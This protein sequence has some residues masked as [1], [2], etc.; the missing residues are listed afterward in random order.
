MLSSDNAPWPVPF[1]PL[2][3][4]VFLSAVTIIT[5]NA[6]GIALPPTPVILPLGVYPTGEGSP[7]QAVAGQQFNGE[8]G[9]FSYE[10]SANPTT[11]QLTIDWGDGTTSGGTL[12]TITLPNGQ[13]A[14][15]VFGSHVYSQPGL[16]KVVAHANED[17]GLGYD[18]TFGTTEA[19]ADITGNPAETGSVIA[20]TNGQQY[21][22][23][24]GQFSAPNG[25]PADAQVSINW[26]DGSTSPGQ[27]VLETDGAYEIVGSHTFE[28]SNNGAYVDHLFAITTTV[29]TAQSQMIATVQSVAVVS[30]SQITGSVIDATS[31]D[32]FSGAL[33][34]FDASLWTD[35]PLYAPNDFL[36][37]TID[38]GDGDQ[39]SGQ[40]NQLSTGAYQI[41]G[42]H[43]YSQNGYYV[44]QAAVWELEPVAG[45]STPAYV[46]VPAIIFSAFNVQSPPAVSVTV[47][48]NNLDHPLFTPNFSTVQI[49][50]DNWLGDDTNLLGLLDN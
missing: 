38:W 9:F 20:A 15:G 39:T 7:I 22:G 47:P 37:A 8:V 21:T 28:L 10:V 29:S 49:T 48:V 43:A 3:E 5:V 11:L 35:S 46:Y 44:A 27:I 34:Q 18:G 12:Q 41:S 36:M 50:T 31:G 16:F 4:R 13:S 33:G 40:I 17:V 32:A 19:I 14:V 6:T 25:L 26:G 23:P 2:E 1:E 42:T 24:V 45:Q 30:G